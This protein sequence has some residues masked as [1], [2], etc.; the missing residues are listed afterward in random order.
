MHPCISD[1]WFVSP[2]NFV[3]EI[4]NKLSLPDRV[5]IHDVT[6]RDGEQQ[7]G[8]VFRKNEKIEIAIALDE[9]GVDRIEVGM[10]TVSQDDFDALK[11]LA[12]QGLKAMV[13][14]FVRCLKSDVDLALKTEVPGVVME[15]PSSEHMIT[16]AYKWPLEKAIGRAA[17]AVEY[18]KQHGLYVSFFTIDATRADMNFFRK[19]VESVHNFMDSLTIA[20]TFGVCTPYTIHYFINKT[21]EFV[22]KPIEIHAHND[23]GL[24]VAN[25][26]AAIAAGATVAHTSVNGIGERAGNADL[27]EVV[28]SLHILLGVK[29]NVK[30]EKLYELSKLVEKYSNVKTPPHKPIV[31]ETPYKI[32]SGII[33][34][35]WL[36]VRE[37]RPVEALPILPTLVGKGDE[38]EIVLGKKSGIAN[39]KYWLAKLGIECRDENTLRSIVFDVKNMSIQLKRPLTIDEF[40]NIIN[41]YKC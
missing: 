39:I 36:N 15:L 13:M 21:K 29:T 34:D 33:V 28:A 17:E 5:V 37:V 18:A 9:A 35:W 1:K 24:A 3:D 12:K 25:T 22:K 19:V 30:L 8:V 41:K 20:D 40:K 11:I 32:E 10:P 23:F 2:Y 16:Y 38:V 4:R 14:A 27:A 7:P 6:L 26:L 31:G